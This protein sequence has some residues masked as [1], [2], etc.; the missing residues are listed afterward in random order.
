MPH[1]ARAVANRLIDL[2]E[3]DGNQLTNLR[4]IHLVYFCH[5]WMLGL[6][7]RP[8]IRQPVEAWRY[9]PV[10]RDVYRSFRQYR[11]GPVRARA[12]VPSARFDAIEEDLIG[13]VY[14]QYGWLP[15]V[16]LAEFTHAE[17]TPW[18]EVW[19]RS[20]QDSII[21]GNL[22]AEHYSGQAL[23]PDG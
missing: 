16:R 4:V 10:I 20:G 19:N 22:L 21:P 23:A 12:R 6:H 11:G 13:R 18:H 17:G 1:D 3:G 7:Q 8:L 9:G 14:R 15:G 5:A 2:A